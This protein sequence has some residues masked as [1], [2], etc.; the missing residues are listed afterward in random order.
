MA[1]SNLPTPILQPVPTTP[2][3]ADEKP[4]LQIIDQSASCCGGGACSID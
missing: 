3:A 2:D 4:T 1:T